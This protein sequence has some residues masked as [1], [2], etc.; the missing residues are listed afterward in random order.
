MKRTLLLVAVFL[1]LVASPTVNAAAQPLTDQYIESIKAGC[2]NALRGIL[3]VQRTEAVTRVNRGQEY[4]SLLKL[5]AAFNGRIVVNN[6]DAPTMTSAGA[7][8]QTK[9]S[10]FQQHYLDYADLV[11]DT[12]KI[13]CKQAPVTFY[14]KLTLT[15]EARAQVATDIREF[16]GLLDEYQRALDGLKVRLSV[17]AG[18]AQ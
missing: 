3:R 4:E 7:K 17:P 2:S 1:T 13:N 15:R 14:D 11:D 5:V 10:D 8:M 18:G 12:L 9:F 16:N 6:R